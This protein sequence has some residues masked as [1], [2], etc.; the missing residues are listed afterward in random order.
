VSV[1][2]P[3]TTK[4]SASRS[5]RLTGGPLETFGDGSVTVR[6][7]GA[8]YQVWSTL[9]ATVRVKGRATPVTFGAAPVKKRNGSLRIPLSDQAVLLPRGKPL[10]VTVGLQCAEGVYCDHAPPIPA[11]SSITIRG[12]TLKLSVLKRAVS[13]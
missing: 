4:L 1:N 12:L 8:D 11:G 5:V 7:S 6:Y 2:L 9:V 10:V 13:R 3:G